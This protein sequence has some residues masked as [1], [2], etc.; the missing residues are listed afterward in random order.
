MT[1][2]ACL[3]IDRTQYDN[4]DPRAYRFVSHPKDSKISCFC[5]I[6]Q[7]IMQVRHLICGKSRRENMKSQPRTSSADIPASQKGVYLFY[8]PPINFHI[9]IELCVNILLTFL[10]FPEKHLRPAS[11]LMPLLLDSRKRVWFPSV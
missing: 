8:S 10:Y 2:H 5:R 1:A 11:K 7:I 6:N 3:I 4:E 9:A